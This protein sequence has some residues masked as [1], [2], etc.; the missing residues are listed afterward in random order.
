M[1]ITCC[2]RSGS[3]P[4][5]LG[6]FVTTVGPGVRA[7]AEEWKESGDYLAS[8]ILQILALE[9]AEGFAELMHQRMR[10]MWGIAD[11]ADITKQDLFQGGLSR[12]TLFIWLPGLSTPW[13]TR[14]SFGDCCKPRRRRIR[15]QSDGGDD[16]GA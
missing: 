2:R 6:A 11:P 13:R 10:A 3:V 14:R 12:Q 4:D 5:Y 9:G 1:P 8:Y 16:D 7:L 15:V